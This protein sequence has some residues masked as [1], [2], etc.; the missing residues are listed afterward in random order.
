MEILVY[1]TITF[2]IGGILYS[3]YSA[4]THNKKGCQA[5]FYAFSYFYLNLFSSTELNAMLTRFLLF[6]KRVSVATLKHN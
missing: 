5:L 2:A 1:F 4:V 3:A 6:K